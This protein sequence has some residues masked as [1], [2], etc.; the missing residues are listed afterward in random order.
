MPPSL[1][2]YLHAYQNPTVYVDPDGRFPVL[3]EMTD[4]LARWRAETTAVADGLEDNGL[5]VPVGASMGL[6]SGLLGL[7]EFG[8][9]ALNTAADV[10]VSPFASADSAAFWLRESADSPARTR[11]RVTDTI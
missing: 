3:R 4:K 2:K 8:A 1:N 7:L 10:A 5:N 9:G 6:G 11:T